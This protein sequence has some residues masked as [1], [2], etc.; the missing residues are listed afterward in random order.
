MTRPDVLSTPDDYIAPVG[1]P[2][3]PARSRGLSATHNR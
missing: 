1:L 3:I 2:E